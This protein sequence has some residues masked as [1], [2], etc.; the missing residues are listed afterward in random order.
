MSGPI[1][2]AGKKNGPLVKACQQVFRWTEPNGLIVVIW[3]GDWKDNDE[4]W[5]ELANTMSSAMVKKRTRTLITFF[6]ASIDEM[7]SKDGGDR[8]PLLFRLLGRDPDSRDGCCPITDFKQLGQA[9]IVFDPNDPETAL[10][11]ESNKTM[12]L[13]YDV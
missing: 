12:G 6:G 4:F 5:M 7:R 10:I 2:I 9:P 1:Y 3:H 13:C 11:L 8:L